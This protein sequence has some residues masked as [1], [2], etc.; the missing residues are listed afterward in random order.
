MK[1][2]MI[3]ASALTLMACGET[4]RTKEELQQ[5]VSELED[6]NGKL[7]SQL[8]EANQHA[9]EAHDA[10]QQAAEAAEAGSV[11]DAEEASQRAA[12]AADDADQASQDQ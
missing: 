2:M 6:E 11:E 12:D 8:E 7:K 3:A 10:A 1:K 9:Q 4:G 5:R